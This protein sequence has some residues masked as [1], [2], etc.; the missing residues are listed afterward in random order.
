MA[1]TVAVAAAFVFHDSHDRIKAGT[2]HICQ[3]GKVSQ[4]TVVGAVALPEP[5]LVSELP[6]IAAGPA[7]SDTPVILPPAR[8]PPAA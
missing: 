6:S 5:M 3:F 2:C 1:F 8:A 7:L 4:S